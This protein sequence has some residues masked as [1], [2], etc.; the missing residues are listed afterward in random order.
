M[1]GTTDDRPLLLA[2]DP[3]RP[4]RGLR[5]RLRAEHAGDL[6]AASGEDGGNDRAFE[7]GAARAF[8]VV[9]LVRVLASAAG[10][11]VVVGTMRVAVAD[12]GDTTLTAVVDGVWSGTEGWRREPGEPELPLDALVP[13]LA[14]PAHAI[15]DEPEARAVVVAKALAEGSRN[16]VARL[17]GL[18]YEVE[19]RI[20]DL[21]ARRRAVVLRNLL[22]DVVELS[23]AFGR[24]R[25]LARWQTRHQLELWRW[26]TG[27]SAEPE[28]SWARTHRAALRHC[29]AMDRE[30]GE[31]VDRLQ[32]LLASMSTFAV[33]QDS[34]AQQRFNLVAATAA[35]GL[36]LPALILSLYGAEAVLP[37]DSVGR[38]VAA[39]GPIAITTLVAVLVA[40]RR[41]PGRVRAR[42]YL[43]TVALVLALVSVLLVAGAL[44]PT[45]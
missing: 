28:P 12:D 24:A 9:P 44:A 6:G 7:R 32:S 42:H 27:G 4:D 25:D 21:L 38:A 34:E 31:E 35:A 36:G 37:L 40:L 11:R 45:G 19:R 3:T 23:L 22:A 43:S 2:G 26:H 8:L 20:A 17:R 10:R 15:P 41:M 16:D 1:L 33:A 14:E 29:E 39:L 5:A 13:A 18:R 30:L